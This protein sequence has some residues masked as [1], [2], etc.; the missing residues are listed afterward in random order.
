MTDIANTV[1]ARAADRAPAAAQLRGRPA[2]AAPGAIARERRFKALGLLGAIADRARPA[3][4]AARRPSSRRAIRRSR[5]PTSGS[6]SPST[7]RSSI[8]R[9]RAIPRRSAR[10]NYAAADHGRAR[11]GC[12]R[13]SQGR[14]RPARAARPRS[15][16]AR[17]CSCASMVLD[18]PTLIGTD[19]GRSGCS[20]TTRSTSSVKGCVD[21]DLPESRP[22][23]RATSRSAGSTSSRRRGPARDCNSTEWLFTTGD[24]REPE[25]AGIWGAVVG[26]FYMMLVTLVLSRADSA[27]PPRSISRSSRPR[28][29]LDRP[30]RGQHQQSRRR[31][32][33]RV[34]PARASR[35]SS[36]LFGLPRS[37]PLVGGLVLALL[38]LPTIIIATRAA[39]R[40]VPPSIRE[41]ALGVG[42]SKL[43]TVTHHVLPLAMPGI[44]TGTIIGMAHALGETAPLLMIGMVAFIVDVPDGAARRRPRR[45]RCRSISGPTARSARSPSG[46]RPRSWCCSASCRDERRSRSTCA[47]GSSADGR[48]QHRTRSRRCEPR[49]MRAAVAPA[50]KM[51]DAQASISGTARSRR[52]STSTSTSPSAR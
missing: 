8:P 17:R 30:D 44:L 24:S 26:S 46:P 23:D 37:A 51:A 9:A 49:A 50:I 41:A 5:R 7:R 45:C 1:A 48:R 38:T 47:R 52:C 29:A 36:T 27:S 4:A 16:R 31:A 33:D 21:R 12:S 19:A 22:P 15:A 2:R 34:R 14:Q 11:R 6:T 43:Q 25:L 18:D 39:L 32:L 10:A 40:A 42:A 3:R 13:T 20:P 35:C 28:T